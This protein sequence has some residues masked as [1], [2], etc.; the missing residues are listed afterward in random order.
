MELA[1]LHVGCQANEEFEKNVQALKQ[2]ENTSQKKAQFLLI[3]QEFLFCFPLFL[4]AWELGM[5]FADVDFM[6][7]SIP[8]TF[9][10]VIS[11]WFFTK[12]LT[13]KR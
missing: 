2:E 4:L 3:I 6:W 13:S 1:L 9:E 8:E 10:M 7:R 12:I 5:R 11:V